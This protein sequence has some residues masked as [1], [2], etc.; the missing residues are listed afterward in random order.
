M[1]N[2]SNYG[3]TVD[4]LAPGEHVKVAI[5]NTNNSFNLKASG[6]SFASPYT[7]GLLALI[8]QDSSIE[9]EEDVNKAIQILYDHSKKDF[10]SEIK[11]NTS[12]KFIFSLVENK[13]IKTKKLFVEVNQNSIEE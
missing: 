10:I 9:T 6:T 3:D 13:P 7:A 8:V 2:H 11:G 1:A 12:N 4:F 5:P